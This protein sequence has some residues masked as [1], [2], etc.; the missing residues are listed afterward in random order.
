MAVTHSFEELIRLVRAGDPAAAQELVQRYEGSIRRAARVQLG[1][2]RL[3]RLLDSTDICQSV[4]A[5]FFLRAA[6]GQYDL[7]KPQQL[8]KLLVMMAHNKV[9]DSA[10]KHA[11]ERHGHQH[12]QFGAANENQVCDPAS[13][14]SQIAAHQELLQRFLEQLTPEERSLAEQRSQGRAWADIAAERGDSPEALRK[15]L[16]RAVDRVAQLLHLET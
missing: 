3:R 4:L 8:V 10:R 5:S 7:A 13:S 9:I 1:D 12:V 11:A 6:L 2:A 16:A 14:P 15:Q